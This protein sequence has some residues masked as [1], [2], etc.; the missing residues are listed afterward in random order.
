MSEL[1][2]QLVVILNAIA[3]AAGRI[4]LSPVAA[5]PGWLS[6]TLVS[7]VT[8]VILLVVFKHTSNQR[9]IKRAR[10]RI[11]ANLLAIKLFKDEPRVAVRSL[12]A[13]L[14]GAGTLLALSLAPMAVMCVPVV[15]MLAQLSLW[16]QARPLKVGEET[17]LSLALDD[18][19]GASLSD[20]RLEPADTLSVMI[21]PVHVRSQRVVVWKVRALQPGYHRLALRV[22]DQRVEKELAVGE[23]F[24]RVSPRRPQRRWLDAVEN[25]AE[26]SFPRGCGI[27]SIEIEYPRRA[28]WASGS[29]SWVIYWFVVSMA[30]GL[31]FKRVFN[32]NM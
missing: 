17:V 26:A 18:Q 23:G 16:Y 15:L 28:G 29:D 21:G 22:G 24:L 4:L 1:A 13:I 10:D 5:L 11:K 31:C 7:A 12:A 27:R 3:N 20:V 30:A 14:A 9:A 8:G 32:V 19:P 25:P 6:V 2:A